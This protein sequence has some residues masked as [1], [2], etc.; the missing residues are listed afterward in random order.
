MMDKQKWIVIR[1][2][3]KA[4]G[5]SVAT[6]TVT[7]ATGKSWDDV[8]EKAAAFNKKP[9]RTAPRKGIFFYIGTCE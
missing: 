4:H 9:E 2:D 3:Y 6:N 7:V 8:M 1:E 5:D